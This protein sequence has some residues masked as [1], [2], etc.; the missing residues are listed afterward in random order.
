MLQVLAAD[1]AA[2]VEVPHCT[3]IPRAN[4]STG[5]KRMRK[6][7]VYLEIADG[8]ETTPTPQTRSRS[9]KVTTAECGL[10]NM[11]IQT[12]MPETGAPNELGPPPPDS[13]P[14]PKHSN[15]IC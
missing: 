12:P 3:Q 10:V 5:F 13:T 6:E 14:A 4:A 7:R 2:D 11:T 9:R 8:G 15:P 1:A